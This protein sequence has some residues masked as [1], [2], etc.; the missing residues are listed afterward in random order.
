MAEK[1]RAACFMHAIH[2]YLGILIYLWYIFYF[3][4]FF[5]G[6]FF[7]VSI[8]SRNI[9]LVFKEKGGIPVFAPRRISDFV[10]ASPL[11]PLKDNASSH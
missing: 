1:M 5:G 7:F 2:Y 3:R 8:Y 6:F 11:P 4:N 9:K 10:Y